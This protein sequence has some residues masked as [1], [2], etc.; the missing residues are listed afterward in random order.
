MAE[1]Y[2]LVQHA[3]NILPRL[4]LLVTV[5][6]VFLQVKRALR[7]LPWGVAKQR[8]AS[9]NLCHSGSVFLIREYPR[10]SSATHSPALRSRERCL[11]RVSSR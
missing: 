11:K 5:A 6:S 8:S 10:A 7:A 1:L 9:A 3:G 2:E 4:Y